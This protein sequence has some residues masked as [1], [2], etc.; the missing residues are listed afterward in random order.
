MI[1]WIIDLFYHSG[2]V[3]GIAKTPP[4]PLKLQTIPRQ[5]VNGTVS[6]LI[7]GKDDEE[8]KKKEEVNMTHFP[9]ISQQNCNR[10]TYGANSPDSLDMEI[11]P[12]LKFNFYLS[13]MGKKW[14]KFQK[15]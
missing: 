12:N 10:V 15:P 1:P 2:L 13:P 14:T 11:E 8:N 5:L 7:R 3:S 9:T 6:I 4:A